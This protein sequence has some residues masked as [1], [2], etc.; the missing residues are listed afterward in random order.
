M[1]TEEMM[2]TAYREA[3]REHKE[4][5]TLR[6]AQRLSLSGW[7]VWST[8]QIG[9]ATYVRDVLEPVRDYLLAGNT[10]MRDGKPEPKESQQ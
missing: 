5:P 3:K 8:G 1:T 4:R 7:D 9:D 10:P 6:S 2:L